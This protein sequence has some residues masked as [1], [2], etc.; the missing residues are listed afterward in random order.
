MK[1]QANVLRGFAFLGFLAAVVPGV[2]TVT[3]AQQPNGNGSPTA[4]KDLERILT[5]VKDSW[6]KQK[7]EIELEILKAQVAAKKAEIEKAEA[8]HRIRELEPTQAIFAKLEQKIPMKFLDETPLEVGLKY[9]KSA[10]QGPKDNGI[11]IYVDP[12]GLNKAEKTMTSPVT[13][14]LEGV[15]LGTTLRLVLKQLG[16]TYE[17]EDG[18]L[19]ITSEGE[20]RK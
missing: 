18:R 11:P 5:R 4:G 8:E 9:I 16:L 20:D 19:T 17:V 12:V 10:T 2:V 7:A 14:D 3:R 1:T 13:L 6:W 15:P